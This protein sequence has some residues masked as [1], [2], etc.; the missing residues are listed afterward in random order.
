MSLFTVCEFVVRNRW[1]P[2]DYFQDWLSWEQDWSKSHQVVVILH[3]CVRVDGKHTLLRYGWGP[4]VISLLQHDGGAAG[5]RWHHRGRVREK[6]EFSAFVSLSVDTG[7]SSLVCWARCSVL[8]SVIHPSTICQPPCMMTHTHTCRLW[9]Y[10]LILALHMS[11]HRAMMKQ[12]LLPPVALFVLQ[13]LNWDVSVKPR[14][15]AVGEEASQTQNIWKTRHVCVLKTHEAVSIDYRI[16]LCVALFTLTVIKKETI[17]RV[18]T[19]SENWRTEPELIIKAPPA[20]NSDTNN[21][22]GAVLV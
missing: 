17:D 1:H 11:V 4:D 21:R 19:A 9:K 15:Q 2:L 18:D 20:A 5:R 13:V 6:E 8:Y 12:H 16:S 14:V 3:V 7:C 10:R 22:S